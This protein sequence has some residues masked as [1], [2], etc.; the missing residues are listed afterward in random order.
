MSVGCTGASPR[1][2]SGYHLIQKG[3]YQALY[4]PDGRLERLVHDQDGDGKADAVIL[5]GPNGTPSR[6]EIDTNGDHRV[7]RWEE[8]DETGRL[9]R[10]DFDAPPSR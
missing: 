2:S 5:Y 9:V 10:V 6:A 4:R 7:D 8:Y 3:A 1:A